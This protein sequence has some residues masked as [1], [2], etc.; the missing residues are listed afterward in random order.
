MKLPLETK[1]IFTETALCLPD[2]EIPYEEI[3]YRKSDT[4]VLQA[5]KLSWWIA[6]TRT[7]KCACRR[8]A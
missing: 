3:F 4:I 8:T 2:Q 1:I 6:A 7:S 5:R